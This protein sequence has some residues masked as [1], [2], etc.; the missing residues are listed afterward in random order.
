MVS[1]IIAVNEDDDVVGSFT[2]NGN[3]LIGNA[4]GS[5]GFNPSITLVGSSASPIDPLL[6]T[7]QNNGGSTETQALE[8]GSPAINQGSNPDNL[9]TDQ[10][11]EDRVQGVAVDIGAYES[12]LTLFFDTLVV[13]NLS[14]END[15][16]LSD[17]DVSLR[18]A[19]ESIADGGTITF[20]NSLLNETI[21]LSEGEL[22]I[23]RSVT[24]NGLGADQLTIDAN[25][26]SRVFNIDDGDN[27]VDATVEISGLTISGGSVT[28]SDDPGRGG[29]IYTRETLFLTNSTLSGNSATSGGGFSLEKT[30]P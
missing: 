5:S 25:Q 16:D 23:D 6:G 15:G 11:G 20:S 1:T 13:D 27:D 21:A 12:D 28:E 14:D 8:S 3:N 19:L 18:E 17:G 10:R 7:L 24:I 29:G 26:Q 4:T 2:D 9:T 22:V 30:S